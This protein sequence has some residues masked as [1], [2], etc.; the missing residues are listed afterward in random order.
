MRADGADRDVIELLV[1]HHDRIKSLLER[2]EAAHGP[3]K[4][5]WFDQLVHLVV[6]HENVEEQIVHPAARA[7][8]GDDVVDTRLREEDEIKTQ[9]A[10]LHEMGTD[11][12][13][14]DSQFAAVAIEVRTHLDHEERDEFPGLRRAL[15]PAKREY[16]A[17]AVRAAE[18]LTPSHPHPQAG[19]H[20]LTNVVAGPPVAAFDMV[21]EAL[22][23][24]RRS[25]GH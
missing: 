18:A 21:R 24:W 16:M 23:R 11:D 19:V 14:F 9:V 7:A 4:H 2:T 25:A 20:R 12:P 22:G 6:I 8:V 1:G 17:R 13:S 15:D 3:D 10:E 5:R